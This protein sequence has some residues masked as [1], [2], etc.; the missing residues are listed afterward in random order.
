MEEKTGAMD[1]RKSG[2]GEKQEGITEKQ[3]DQVGKRSIT[4]KENQEEML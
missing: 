2:V 4:R 1:G 3:N